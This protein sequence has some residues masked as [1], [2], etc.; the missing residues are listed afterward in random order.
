MCN[1]REFKK[2]V[3]ALGATVVEEMMI[4][5]YN[6][7]KADKQAIASAVGNLLAATDNARKNANVTFDKGPRAFAD[8]K[9]YSKAKKQFYR[10]LFNKISKEFSEEVKNA[11]KV[12]NAS[13][14]AEV[15]E[16]Q[17]KAVAE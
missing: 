3:D 6:E 7:E 12:L 9:E 17:K 4:Q 13:L 16:A 2:Y 8:L 10:A 15:K 1:K 5:F 11:V 14:P